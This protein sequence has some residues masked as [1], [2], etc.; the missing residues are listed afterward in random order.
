MKL[1]SVV[2]L[3]IAVLAAPA[4]AQKRGA[5][6][7]EFNLGTSV[8]TEPEKKTLADCAGEVVFMDIWGM[9]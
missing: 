9:T 4:F 5:P 1:T 6:A 8:T 7:T 2:I 3:L